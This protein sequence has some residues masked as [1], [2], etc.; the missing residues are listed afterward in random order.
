MP[1]SE[2]AAFTIGLLSEA[3]QISAVQLAA[4]DIAA[5]LPLRFE[6]KLATPCWVDGEN[7]GK[8][9]CLPA[10]F[11]AGG[12]Q[13]GS[14]LLWK[15]LQVHAHVP[16][17]HDAL[18]H[19][20]TLHPR[21]RAGTFER[22]VSLF[23]TERTLSAIRK[24][25]SSLL[26]EASPATFGF[27]MAEQLR[28]HYLYL[29]AFS[30]CHG[31]CR[32]RSPPAAVATRCADRNYDLAHCYSEANNATVPEAFNL[33]SLIATV[34]RSRLPKVIALLRDPSLRLWIAFWDY[35]QYPARY[36]SSQEGFGA[37][38]GNQSAAFDACVAT[39][40]RG[41]R[42]CALRFE[43]YGA[44]EAQVYYHA[45][46]LVKGM[47]SA[48][49]PEWQAALDPSRLLIMR[50]ED[51]FAR[52]MHALR[53]AC[54]HLG[55]RPLS[56]EELKAAKHV[57]GTDELERVQG[58]H[59]LPPPAIF[60]RVRSFYEPFNRALVHQLGGDRAF[61]WP[62]NE[63]LASTSNADGRVAVLKHEIR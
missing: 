11:I 4:P 42:R 50:A 44:K 20:W 18:S 37:Y 61:L 46:Q 7:G 54:A 16:S 40:G 34:M 49:L 53:R 12:M 14:G 13:C 41:R 59:G 1:D 30:A 21:S 17:Q 48:F 26:G 28:L 63:P 3:E 31:R 6:E 35:G 10:F 29:D 25:P 5:R 43:A 15:R 24:E 52:P 23:S 2:A 60:A 8:L 33:P 58:A 38:F 57:R 19:W 39:D 22:Y 62:E 32:S 56:V 27:M 47:Y 51:Q 36:G 45:D 9:K 55:L